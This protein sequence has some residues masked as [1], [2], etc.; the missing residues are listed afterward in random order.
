MAQFGCSF[1][2]Q[3]LSNLR[4]DMSLDAGKSSPVA[5]PAST[6]EVAS[7]ELVELYRRFLT[8]EQGISQ[9]EA[10]G[11]RQKY[12][13]NEVASE[14]KSHWL[15]KL[16]QNFKDPLSLLLLALGVV[17]Y[18]T[19]DIKATMLIVVMLVLSVVLRFI[20]ELKAD[21]AAEKL[22]ALVRTTATVVREGKE[23][24]IPLNS[25][26]PGDVVKLSAGDMVPADVRLI[27]SKDLF[28]NQ[29]ALTGESL[30]AEKHAAPVVNFSG[31][32]FELPNICFMGTGVDTG[33]A[34]AV[35]VATGSSTK[36]GALAGKLSEARE[37][38]SFDVGVGKFTW[39][40][41]RFIGV[42]V[43]LVFVVNGVARGSWVEAFMFAL[44]VGVGLTPELLPMIVT[45]NLS[46]G[47]LAMSKQKVIVK[48]LNA[49]QN[50]GAMD[51][52]CTDK[53]G[54]L[55]K[56][57][58]ELIRHLGLDGQERDDILQ[59]AY[60][61]STYQTG[62]KNLLD[63]AV[64]AHD[65]A[66]S[67]AV[68][69]HYHKIDEVPFDFTRRR[70]SV[71]VEDA[72]S[73]KHTLICKGAV[74][75]VMGICTQ[76]RLG[77]GLI[78]LAQVHQAHRDALVQKLSAEG[79]RLIA[80]AVRELPADKHVYTAADECDLTLVGFLAFL[81]PPKPTAGQALAELKH[82]GV[83]VVILTGDNELVARKVCTEVGLK[84]ER[85]VL[86]SEVETMNGDDLGRTAEAVD[87]F[88]KLE[89]HHKERIIRSLRS[90]GHVVGYMGDGINDAPALRAA[91]VGV[92]V[93]SAVDIAK[94]ASDIIL[95]EKNLLVLRAGVRDG[96]KVFGNIVKYIRMTASSNFGNMFSVVGASAFLPFLPMLPIQVIT[97][98]LM[99]DLSQVTI[100]TDGVDEEYL[101][102]PRQWRINSIRK[103]ILTLGPVSSLFDFATFA[104][105]A[106]GFAGLTNPAL[107]RT[108][109]FV[110]SL[111]SQTLIIH[112]IRT[113]RV[114][115]LQ[116][117]AS[118][119][120]TV[121]S[122][123]ICAFGV[124]LPFSSLAPALGFVPLPASYFGAVALLLL[125]YFALAH[126]AQRWFMRK[127]GDS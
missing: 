91:D 104:L 49:I 50:F 29:A 117:R 63:E 80:L 44:A 125:A 86:G 70:M 110:E 111:L 102:K 48:R 51:V 7:Y 120:L 47:A 28:I 65:R 26:V 94:E 87:V 15:N 54:T 68:P 8:S 85:V 38:S 1:L 10:L 78:T 58:V 73:G 97:N 34:S 112:I 14:I 57:K 71:V 9:A 77:Q 74:E 20:Q 121:S 56:G 52:L 90:K 61:N 82:Y 25:L 11:R 89:P 40:M 101:K 45:V 31:S 19:G 37:I 115:F 109:W 122:L 124:W 83:R 2:L 123:L 126:L 35:V 24:E 119:T 18:F 79:F 64:L 16:V 33:V 95:L 84:V 55:T 12:G 6:Q 62:L 41:I 66:A 23:H 69:H 81:D 13:A 99:Y 27:E 3:L 88:A 105:L 96:R 59:Y 98:N 107:F 67:A 32:E 22:R 108:G 100:P 92:S 46:Q 42:M 60:L 116:S 72:R 5:V 21:H 114:P 30:P 39:L 4:S 113:N 76:A 127:F 93:D 43:P 118:V 103:Y 17:S 75:E 36:F 53:T 106:W